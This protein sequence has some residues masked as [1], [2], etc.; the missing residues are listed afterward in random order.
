MMW[1]SNWIVF[2]TKKK[3]NRKNVSS[4]MSWEE[5]IKKR[6][7]ILRHPQKRCRKYHKQLYLYWCPWLKP[8]AVHVAMSAIIELRDIFLRHATHHP[9]SPALLHP[10]TPLL[11]P[12]CRSVL[13]QTSTLWSGLA[14][15]RLTVS[16]VVAT[17]SAILWTRP[18]RMELT[19][20]TT[21]T[22]QNST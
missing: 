2:L 16:P 5:S 17:I 11:P 13:T 7:L 4:S 15:V 12:L 8:E 1:L 18:G 20:R 6:P 14:S 21:G 3:S 22:L 9:L 10:P 19:G